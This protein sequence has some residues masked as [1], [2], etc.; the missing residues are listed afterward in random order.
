MAACELWLVFQDERGVCIFAVDLWRRG[1]PDFSLLELLD[2]DIAD[3]TIL[4]YRDIA[5]C[6]ILL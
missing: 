2:R 6:T 5:D 1:L 4:L 3:C